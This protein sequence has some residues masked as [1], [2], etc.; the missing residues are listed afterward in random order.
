MDEK[1]KYEKKYRKMYESIPDKDKK[2]AEELISRLADVLVMMDRCKEHIDAEGFVTS[3]PQGSYSIDRENPYS[4]IYSDKYKL[5]LS[6][7]DKLDKMLPDKE[8]KITKAGENLAKLVAGGKPV[9]VR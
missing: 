5:M 1:K 3:M 7:L 4:K 9:E 8:E 6:T 2:K